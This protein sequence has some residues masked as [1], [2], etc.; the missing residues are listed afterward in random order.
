MQL[1]RPDLKPSGTQA[2]RELL[3]LHWTFPPELVRPLVPAE[4]DLDPR[5][6]LAYVGVVPFRMADVRPAFL[7]RV[8]ALNFL[9]LNVRTYVRYR[10]RPGVYFFSLEAASLLAVKG[11]R[12]GW[13]LPYFRA[14]MST[15][16]DG[17]VVTYA[18]T[19]RDRAA[20]HHQVRYRL[21]DLLPTTAPD[22]LEDFLLERY[23]LFTV[24]KGRVYEGQVFHVPYPAQR[25]ELLA[26]DDQLV[27]AA[28]L[29]DPA[30]APDTVHYASGVDVEVFGP[31]PVT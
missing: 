11:A 14:R 3:F 13:G 28:G 9:E 29:P 31:Y 26:V 20:P 23:L 18:S 25:A 12:W 19:R 1:P 8:F 6:G 2:W 21:G 10:G 7:P 24:Q 16:T 30:R 4:L 27:A 15:T 22:T 5:D 17:D